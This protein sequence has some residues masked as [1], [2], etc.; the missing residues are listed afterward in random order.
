MTLER[1]LD[2][3]M[4]HH[5]AGRLAEA[6]AIYRRVLAEQP[7]NARALHLLGTLAGQ[8][9]RFDMAA[10]LI[11]QV[12]RLNPDSADAHHNLS[13]AMRNLGQFDESVAAARRAVRLDPKHADAYLS[14][15]NTLTRMGKLDEAIAAFS[16]AIECRPRWAMPRLSLGQL[17]HEQGRFE[18]ARS[19]FQQ[20]AHFEPNN[21]DAHNCLAM[22]LADLQRLHEA[23]KALDRAAALS[24]DSALTHE[25]R[26]TILLRSGHGAKAVD[27]FRRAL[28][29]APEWPSGWINL[30]QALRQIGR[31]TEAADCFRKLHALRSG[32]V[33]ASILMAGVAASADAAEIGRLTASLNDPQTS[34]A[35]RAALGFVLGKMLDE[36]DRFDEAF[37]HYARANSLLLQMRHAAGER[38]DSDQFAHRVDDLI[39]AFTPGFFAR[40]RG[41]GEPSDLPVF[42]VGMPRSGTSL[43]E[44]IASSHPDIFGAGELTDIG[45]IATSLNLAQCRPAQVSDAARKHLDRL[46]VLGG[47]ASRVID[48]MPPNVE[49]LGLIA[50][51]FPSARIILCRRDPRDTCLSCFFQRFIA[52]NLFSFDLTQCG[53][54]HVHTDRLIA[55]WLKVLPLQILQIQ[56]EDLIG[57]L[58]GQSRRIV[59]FLGLPLNPAC[60]DFHRTERTVQTSSAWQVRQPIYSRSVSRWRNYERHLA[61]LFQALELNK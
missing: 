34:I 50:T 24:P 18:E 39:A 54:H 59:N 23:A 21:S 9:G 28:E 42:I 44:Q 57:D 61:P 7:N 26:G 56:Y 30:G 22:S 43:V 3:G 8:C 36:A 17:F 41:W 25:A 10:D 4:S 49:H 19:A 40:T 20:V 51:L 14:L 52:G 37:E 53:R 55:H 47:S 13:L 48:K 35:D 5:Q 29:I 58:E 11:R 27:C 45:D 15:G 12:I 46:R 16:K 33:Q 2:S 31:F 32:A 60:L 1:Q 6:E 38:Y